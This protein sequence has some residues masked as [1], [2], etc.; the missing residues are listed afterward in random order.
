[1]GTKIQDSAD[2][3]LG[4]AE[5]RVAAATMA[6]SFTTNSVLL[7]IE[8]ESGELGSNYL[9]K[10]GLDGMDGH[11]IGCNQANVVEMQRLAVLGVGIFTRAEHEEGGNGSKIHA[12][13][14]NRVS[15]TTG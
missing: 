5:E 9:R 2:G 7:I 13:L 6:K 15:G 8:G 12:D 10:G 14:V 1:M 3:G 11:S 4:G